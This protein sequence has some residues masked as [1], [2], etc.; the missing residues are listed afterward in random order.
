MLLRSGCRVWWRSLA[1][2][3]G[4]YYFDFSFD[5]VA[6]P[7]VYVDMEWDNYCKPITV[8]NFR[9][10]LYVAESFTAAIMDRRIAEDET[11]PTGPFNQGQFDE[12]TEHRN[13]MLGLV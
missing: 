5:E 3:N 7:L 6:P 4:A 2:R 11:E 8:K 9:G 12:W 10:V 13:R 1:G